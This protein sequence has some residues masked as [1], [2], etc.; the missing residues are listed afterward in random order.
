MKLYSKF[1]LLAAFAGTAV[2]ASAQDSYDANT[3]STSDLNGTS[4]F[5]SMGGALGAL[6]GDISVM[7]TNP[8]GTG[9]YRRSDGAFTIGGVFSDKGAMGHDRA[10]MS[11]DQGGAVFSFDMQS[12]TSKGLQYVNFGVNYQ[13]NRNFLNN[14]MIDVQHLGTNG[15]F[16]QTG[17]IADMA[18]KCYDE[19]LEKWGTLA[20]LSA[21]IYD[22]E[23]VLTRPGIIEEDE[24][25]YFGVGAKD[26]YYERATFGSTSQIDAN[27]SFN[28]SDKFFYGVSLGIYDVNYTRESFYSELGIDGNAYDFTNW[29]ETS[30]TGFD[31]KFGFICRPIDDSPFRFGLTVHTPTWYA[32]TDANGADLY[33][34]DEHLDYLENGAFDYQFRTPWKFGVSLGHTVGKNFAIGAEWEYKDQGSAHY[35]SAEG[36][37]SIGSDRYFKD[38]N[39]FTKDI[40]KG[41]HTLKLGAEYKPIDE[42]AFRIGYNYLTSPFKNDAYRT[43]TYDGPYT[44][45]DYTNWKDTH[46]FTLGVGYRFKGGYLDLA[47]QYQTQKGDFYAFDQYDEAN[48]RYTLKPTSI[49]NDRS[50][51]MA[52]LGFRF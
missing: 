18:N 38:V 14:M 43:I 22:E 50:H 41:Q 31:L 27:L 6:G 15:D 33:L 42:V 29:Y 19:N 48:P 30:G 9:L 7:S 16:S 10:R 26:A 2:G 52:T 13:K 47:Y 23:G 24:Y 40:L 36:D 12:P 17:Q 20:D 46:R 28:V 35:E 51:L 11:I 4:R 21:P 37:Y 39:R 44:E 32:M 34:N 45:T 25:G 49:D 1:L 5:V 8:A 3:F